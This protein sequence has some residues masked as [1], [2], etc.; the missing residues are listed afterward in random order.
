[1]GQLCCFG[2]REEHASGET[3]STVIL[4]ALHPYLDDNV[5]LTL[6]GLGDDP[7]IAEPS[8]VP[9][10]SNIVLKSSCELR[11]KS[12]S[13]SLGGVAVLSV[14][15]VTGRFFAASGVCCRGTFG[16]DLL[17]RPP[18]EKVRPAARS[19]LV[20]GGAGTSWILECGDRVSSGAGI[21]VDEGMVDDELSLVDVE[22]S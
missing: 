16:P 22:L 4:S 21:S 2:T 8:R 11:A 14:L 15:P 3:R 12:V 10:L 6:A 7:R 9:I 20:S 17:N 19:A 1:M 18:N 5:A 13:G